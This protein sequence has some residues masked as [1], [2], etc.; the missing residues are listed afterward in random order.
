P[1]CDD[2][3][4]CTT[5]ECLGGSCLNT[6]L[7]CPPDETC[8]GGTCVPVGACCVAQVCST[9]T[10]TNCSTSGGTYLGDGTP[11]RSV[12]VYQNSPGTSIP[13]GGGP[14]DPA[15]DT[16]NVPDAFTVGDVDV[17]LSVTHTWVGDLTVT[18]THLGT[19]V[20]VLD[21]P[22]VPVSQFGCDTD[23]YDD[24]ILDDEG[25][26][27]AIE[28]ACANGL[29]SPP[30][31]R[32]NSPLSAFDGMTSAGDWVINVYDSASQDSGT[33]DI[34]SIHIDEADS[35]PCIGVC[36]TDPDCDD[37]NEC[38][39]ETCNAGTCEYTNLTDPCDDLLFCNGD[40]M[41]AGGSCS[42][43]TGDP[44]KSGAE[45][46]DTCDEGTG[47]C[48]T[49]AGTPC[50]EDGNLCTDNECDGAGNCAA[51]GNTDLCDDGD[52]CTE[53]DVC[54]GDEFGTCAGTFADDDGDG[55]CNAEDICP[56]GDDTVDSDGDG[57]PDACDI[58]SPILA[59]SPHDVLKNR[60]IS[61]DPRGV[62]GVNEGKNLDIRLTLTSTLVIGVT[63]I[64]SEW[65]AN[66]PDENC[67]STVGP[68]RPAAA[69]NWD[70]CPTLHLTGCPIM[71]KS[72]Y[73]IVVVDDELVSDTPLAAAT[74][75]K[76]G[77][78]CWGDLVG[79]F[80]GK[81]WGPPNGTVNA[82]DFVAVIKSFVDP[83]A[84]NAVHV[85]L[86]DLHPAV[87]PDHP[88]KLCNGNDILFTI[89]GFQAQEYPGPD[90]DLCPDP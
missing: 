48:N 72:I 46:A 69:P 10:E 62:F 28:V 77:I 52:D 27:G 11:C 66:E 36:L 55:V 90:I 37:D 14:G 83:N 71:P 21:Q 50:T 88:N 22:G 75:A 44:C 26:G 80:D 5:D 81:I 43:H 31:Y 59:P 34:W 17:D 40:D 57:I 54:Q 18:L 64:D 84:F 38:T 15:V 19:T 4:P 6:P 68:S 51:S 74:Q 60:Y 63:A 73:T 30:N 16:I 42:I 2:L 20:T 1:D 39:D 3:D 13:D 32:P 33:L 8:V 9:E 79:Q 61:I 82:D 65:W 85:S 87:P 56:G 89:L 23:D 78:K 45:C 25:A 76:P 58:E 67:I 49:P 35:N 86:C 24:I 7:S 29:S 12:T 70:A 53:G 47:T 41:C